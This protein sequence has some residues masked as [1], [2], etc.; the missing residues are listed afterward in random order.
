M[1]NKQGY[2]FYQVGKIIKVS[3]IGQAI[4]RIHITTKLVCKS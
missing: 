4:N 3:K 1:N 2:F